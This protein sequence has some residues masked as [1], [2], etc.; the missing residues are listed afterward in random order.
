V[1]CNSK[2]N[3]KYTK[4][5]GEH[6]CIG[7]KMC[8]KKCP[9]QAIKVDSF[10]ASIDYNKCIVCGACVSVC[11]TGAI[12]DVSLLRGKSKTAAERYVPAEQPVQ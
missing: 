10:L 5:G 6:G 11:P 1:R 8:E 12:G 4:D 2:H 9:T 3:G 7:C